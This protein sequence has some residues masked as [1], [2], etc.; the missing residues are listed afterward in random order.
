MRK[1]G[2]QSRWLALLPAGAVLLLII[3][4]VI[5]SAAHV[6][7]GFAAYY[8]ASRAVLEER[9]GAWFYDDATFQ[10]ETERATS[11]AASDIYYA[12]PPTTALLF[13]PIAWLPIIAARQ[14]WIWASFL[15]SLFAV[16]FFAN[17]FTLPRPHA[18]L[19]T[20]AILFSAPLADNIRFG[21]AYVF[22]LALIII[23]A[24]GLQRRLHWLA[25]LGLGVSL[26]L[27]ASGAPL[28][29]LLLVRREWRVLAWAVAITAAL[30]IGALPLLGTE[31]W[32]TFLQQSVPSILHDPA[33]A[34]TSYQTIASFFRHLFQYH[35]TWS[36]SPLADWPAVASTLSVA[37]SGMLISIAAI[38]AP[39]KPIEW[40]LCVGLTLSVILVPAAEQHHYVL[41]FPVLIYL[42]HTFTPPYVLAVALIL[43]PL[44]YAQPDLAQGWLALLAYP[45]LYGAVILLALLY[46]KPSH[47]S[48]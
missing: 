36:P 2:R 24:V 33:V 10:A 18:A 5:P 32:L 19:L 42:A 48:L 23:T 31:T 30:I 22:L 37:I 46:S 34:S 14:M 44:P 6:T 41:L 47:V 12:N 28:W 1:A 3:T 17:L 27:K 35:P 25:G 4:T 11:G 16:A 15:L 21:Q 38:K 39:H 9:A 13:L 43:I 20:T 7:H 40:V 26:T 8:T 29:I 45:R